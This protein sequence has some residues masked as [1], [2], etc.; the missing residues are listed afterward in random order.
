LEELDNVDLEGHS[1]A[2]IED[3]SQ[4]FQ[5]YFDF[6]QLDEIQSW[7]PDKPFNRSACVFNRGVLVIDTKRWQDE[8]ITK[9]IVWWMDEFRKSGDKKALYKYALSLSL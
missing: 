6:A 5:V 4:R 3:C 8:N 2:A 7:L 1:V 9:A